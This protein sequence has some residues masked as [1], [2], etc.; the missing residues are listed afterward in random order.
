MATEIS[1]EKQETWNKL[2][3]RE[4]TSATEVFPNSLLFHEKA[5]V[6]NTEF[7]RAIF[8]ELQTSFASWYAKNE[9]H[10]KSLV[11]LMQKKGIPRQFFKLPSSKNA[12]LVIARALHKQLNQ[13]IDL[14][15]KKDTAKKRKNF[16]KT[17]GLGVLGAAGV[18]AGVAG[19]GTNGFGSSQAAPIVTSWETPGPGTE[20]TATPF[21]S[22][23]AAPATVNLP[24]STALLTLKPTEAEKLADFRSLQRSLQRTK[25][26]QEQKL[27]R[28]KQEQEQ[29][30][31]D[32]ENAEFT[33][34]L[35]EDEFKTQR[36]QARRDR[37]LE[38]ER[39]AIALG[40]EETPTDFDATVQA[41]ETTAESLASQEVSHLLIEEYVTPNW[42]IPLQDMTNVEKVRLVLEAIK[43]LEKHVKNEE[44]VPTFELS[45]MH[46][47]L[48]RDPETGTYSAHLKDTV[49]GIKREGGAKFDFHKNWEENV[50]FL[51]QFLTEDDEII[52]ES[53][54]ILDS[55]VTLSVWNQVGISGYYPYLAVHKQIKILETLISENKEREYLS[56]FKPLTVHGG[57]K[58][59]K[60]SKQK[61]SRSRRRSR[62]RSGRR[63][64]SRRSRRYYAYM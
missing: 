42:W 32:L 14:Q 5:L 35:A 49:K 22:V 63:K 34:S 53:K 21:P 37:D 17:V 19:Y 46:L 38:K 4:A 36:I 29:K 8:V 20:V 10:L 50:K 1:L 45:N 59:T 27:R 31:A 43:I 23:A 25:Q 44:L 24:R 47:A 57:G 39:Q 60:S 33:K 3:K 48:E 64:S 12:Q 52:V 16:F 13:A 51:E 58:K 54:A 18:A 2:V 61:H 11:Q 28:T 9:K 41:G 62:S 40:S 30:D 26:E 7:I 56:S 6:E 15:T 55:I